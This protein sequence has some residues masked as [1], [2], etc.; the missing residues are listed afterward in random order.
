MQQ[1]D[2]LTLKWL[3]AELEQNL[4]GAKVSKVQHPSAREFIISFWGGASRGNQQN[5][6]YI[7]LSPNAPF[8]LLVDNKTRQSVVKAEFEK[9]TGLCMHLRKHLG[10]AGLLSVE[11]LDGERVI[12]FHFENYNELGQKVWLTLSLE[13]MGKH[14]NMIFFDTVSQ[15]IMAV[16]HGVS[17]S[18]SSHRELAGGLPYAPPPRQAGKVLLQSVDLSQFQSCLSQ[19]KPN[20]PIEKVIGRSFFGFGPQILT[21]LFQANSELASD[22]VKALT[23]LQIINNAS[24]NRETVTFAL[25][26]DL[27]GF[28]LLPSTLRPEDHNLH[29][30]ANAC[31]TIYFIGH[32]LKE[33]LRSRREQ[34]LQIVNQRLEKRTKREQQL[35][36]VSAAEIMRLQKL[37]ERLLSAYG[38]NEVEGS[39]PY[40]LTEISLPDYET[41]APQRIQLEPRLSW[42]DN[43][44]VYF[45]LAKKAKARKRA[46]EEQSEQLE[47]ELT[48]LKGLSQWVI[49]SETLDELDG[50]VADM[51]TA[52]FGPEKHSFNKEKAKANKP[53]KQSKAKKSQGAKKQPD[54]EESLQ[55]GVTAHVSKDGYPILIGKSG[56]GN[57]TIVGKL[58]RSE[59]LWLH[60][61]LMPGSHVLIRTGNDEIPNSTLLEAAE[62]A[63]YY[64]AGRNSV[65]VPVI[66]TRCKFVRKIPH[67]YPGHVNYRQ[68]QTIFVTPK[69]L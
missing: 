63:A 39:G 64:S 55:T 26:P 44:Q 56:R 48:F 17:E 23:A 59:D 11:T 9:P 69:S 33:R 50:V 57:D 22:S 45:R 62:L 15:E 2:A 29:A 31:L 54:S 27:S 6:L 37:G 61:H 25:R 24:V 16:A 40:T 46:H 5:N 20:E 4:L 13:L 30:S 51:A 60:A 18:M 42:V 47:D 21:A 3:A 35:Q 38:A 68:E 34:L 41:E 65:N 32:L 43:A 66:Y 67:S 8:C 14:S 58:S 52:G 12:N 7:H 36:P 1:L 28:A 19:A 53:G 49:Q 10:G